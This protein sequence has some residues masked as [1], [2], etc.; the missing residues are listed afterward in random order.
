MD[1]LIIKTTSGETITANEM[2]IKALRRIYKENREI[3]RGATVT[4]IIIGKGAACF[5]IAGGIKHLNAGVISRAGLDMLQKAGIP[6]CPKQI[7]PMIINRK[8][9]G[10]CPI[11][12][13]L[14]ETFEAEEGIKKISAFFNDEYS[15]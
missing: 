8:N 5:L 9:D 7:V 3:L 10:Q 12:N 15:V 13:L 11:E 4:D 6:V 2:G 14:R 1:K